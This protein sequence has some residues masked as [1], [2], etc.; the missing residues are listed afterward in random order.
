MSPL[1]IDPVKLHPIGCGLEWNIRET[2]LI[3]RRSSGNPAGEAEAGV[4]LGHYFRNLGL[5]IFSRL[6][7][8]FSTRSGAEGRV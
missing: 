2:P 7:I 5:A 8:S 1:R 6:G 3:H 4:W